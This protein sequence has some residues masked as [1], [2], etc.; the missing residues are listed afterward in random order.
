MKSTYEGPGMRAEFIARARE[1]AAQGHAD[2]RSAL[3]MIARDEGATDWA[4]FQAVCAKEKGAARSHPGGAGAYLMDI[5]SM[6]ALMSGSADRIRRRDDIAA[7]VIRPVF[8]MTSHLPGLTPHRAMVAFVAFA[9]ILSFIHAILGMELAGER[10][11]AGSYGGI[12]PG[13]IIMAS[14]F[15]AWIASRFVITSVDPVRPICRDVRANAVTLCAFRSLLITILGYEISGSDVR[16]AVIIQF[17][18]IML[19]GPAW[20]MTLYAS[21]FAREMHHGR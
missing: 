4:S 18:A 13:F 15:D 8:S 21:R 9:C 11:P 7:A 5:L 2:Y 20:V 3:D 14:M 1:M 16:A 10:M 17:V 12:V 19:S 6:T